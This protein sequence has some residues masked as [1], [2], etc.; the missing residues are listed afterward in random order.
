MKDAAGVSRTFSP[1]PLMWTLTPPAAEE[2]FRTSCK[3]KS[4]SSQLLHA[5]VN[6]CRFFYWLWDINVLNSRFCFLTLRT[7]LLS[8]VG[9]LPTHRANLQGS[10]STCSV[11]PNSEVCKDDTAHL[12]QFYYKF[13]VSYYFTNKNFYNE[14]FLIVF[15][16]GQLTLDKLTPKWY[17]RCSYIVIFTLKINFY[18]K[19]F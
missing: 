19:M 16:L 5:R 13:F 8:E 14:F 1:T 7:I 15:F 17:R 12:S 2:A 4:I 3:I 10:P 9:V 18:V 6:R 11:T